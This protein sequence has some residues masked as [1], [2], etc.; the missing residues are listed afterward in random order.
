VKVEVVD[1]E[2]VGGAAE[3]GAQWVGLEVEGGG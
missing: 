2:G 1:F 3:D